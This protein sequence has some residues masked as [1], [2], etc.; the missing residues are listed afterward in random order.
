MRLFRH[1][2]GRAKRKEVLDAFS[3][4]AAALGGQL[5][6]LPLESS[7]SAIMFCLTTGRFSDNRQTQRL[8]DSAEV[9]VNR[10]LLGEWAAPG[11][12]APAKSGSRTSS[13]PDSCPRTPHF[14]G[15]A[16]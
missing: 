9:R 8:I 12:R 2:N 14:I 1:L 16:V 15:V 7:R 10:R 11:C 13:Q 6:P 4:T 5:K 3:V